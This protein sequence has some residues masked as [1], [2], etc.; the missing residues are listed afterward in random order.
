M[1]GAPAEGTERLVV[2][3]P[4]GMKDT[5]KDWAGRSDLNMGQ[6]VRRILTEAIDKENK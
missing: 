2:D 1:P 5:L 6:L 3:V 4:A